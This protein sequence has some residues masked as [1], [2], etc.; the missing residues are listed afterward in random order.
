MFRTLIQRLTA[1]TRAKSRRRKSRLARR[2]SF[3]SDM[4]RH[5]RM[6]ALEERALLATI[7]VPTDHATIQAAVN[8]SG[9]GDTIQI[10]SGTYNE[11]VDVSAG[12]G[13]LSFIGNDTGT[14]LPLIDGNAAPAFFTTAETAD[15]TFDSLRLQ[16]AASGTDNH[17]IR[18]LELTGT[19]QVLGSTFV[20][21]EDDGVFVRA[22]GTVQTTAFISGNTFLDVNN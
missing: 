22:S 7:V 18:L 17:S 6:E 4:L 12:P 15:Y 21:S 2:E 13:S 20:S 3:Q 9:A 16:N 19:V 8:A 1:S 10:N 14:G 11:S 5:L